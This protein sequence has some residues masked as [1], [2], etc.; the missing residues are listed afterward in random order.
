MKKSNTKIMFKSLF[1]SWYYRLK[2]KGK[3]IKM[4]N[5]MLEEQNYP[6]SKLENIQLS[7]LRL[8]ISHA[9]GNVP[10]YRELFDFAKINPLKIKNLEDF[11]NLP[12]ITKDDLRRNFPERI[13]AGNVKESRFVLDKTSGSTNQPF[14]FYKDKADEVR[15]TVS[16][17][18]WLVN[19]GYILG[20]GRVLIRGEVPKGSNVG[21]LFSKVNFISAF[22]MNNSEFEKLHEKLKKLKPLTIE[23][24]PSS[25]VSF[26]RYLKDQNKF[27][28]IP[29]TIT[30]GEMVTEENRKLIEECLNSEVFDS[31]GSS[32][33]MYMA[34]ECK[35]HNGLHYDMCNFL[36]EI[37]DSKGR[38]VKDG[39][40]GDV[41]VTHLNNFAMPIIRYKIG[42]RAVISDV[43][44]TCG[45]NFKKIT[46][47]KGRIVDQIKTPSGKILD[48]PFLAT[49]FENEV[50]SISHYQIIQKK[51]NLLEI[52]IVLKN[53][54][55]V[56]VLKKINKIVSDYA[57]HD[58]KIIVK[59]V[60]S[61][62][63]GKTGKSIFIKS[64]IKH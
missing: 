37:V 55:D 58:M 14:E 12:V 48:F 39:V 30:I 25:I 7:K 24:Y 44:C 20:N 64:E 26:A 51:H 18:R 19:S 22:G 28:T 3:F 63:L 49:I 34:Q 42:D 16:R 54:S 2:S 62:P 17:I 40:E 47:I 6:I 57:G 5:Q 21:S 46:K 36:I 1:Y 35:L 4:V 50:S 32:E 27:L 56:N 43:Q 8:L 61:I 23:S 38:N 10:F 15:E 29:I 41:V 33:A 53:K 13:K 52:R 60:G 31:Y 9:D 59:N 45:I 11:E